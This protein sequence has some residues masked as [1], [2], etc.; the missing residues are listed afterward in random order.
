MREDLSFK[1]PGSV[2]AGEKLEN[3]G[4]FR[5]KL[6]LGLLLAGFV[7]IGV[8]L[9]TI[10]L[11]RHDFWVRYVNDQR[12]SAIVIYPKRGTIYD[13]NR[14]PLATSIEQEVLCVAPSRVTD[15]A[16][17][18][19]AISPYAKMR[20]KKIADKIHS[21]KLQL[22]YLRRGLDFKTVKEINAKK[23]EG[24]EFRSEI[25]RHYPNGSHASNLI[26]FA[27]LENK[28]LEGIEYKY[29]SHLAGEAGKQIVI[30][31]N[32]RREIAVLAQLVKE[33]RDGGD[34]VLTID[35]YIQHTTEKALDEI[36]RSF[37]PES[38]LAIVVEPKTG[39]V[40][41]MACRPT[42]DPNEPS[43]YKPHRLRN[44][45]ITDAFEPGSAFKAIAAASALERNV[46]TPRSHVYCEL[47]SMRFHRHTYNDVHPLADVTFA[48]VIA[49]SS[50]IG[51]IKVT[52]LLSP[53]Y[54]YG[55]IK[56]FGFGNP[57]GIDLPGES[58]GIVHHPS[59]WS[60]LSMG[61]LPIGQEI[62][63]TALQLAMAYSAIA[64]EGKLMRPF[65]I[66]K[67]LA[68]D[69]T[70]LKETMP[71][72]VR[73]V[74]RPE[75]AQTLTKLLELVITSGTGTEARIAGY[76]CAGK[77]GTAQKA[78]P[79]AGG[80]YRDKHVAVFSGFLPADDPAACITIVV[81]SPRGKKYYG[82]QVAAPAFRDIGREIMNHLEFPPTEL[83]DEPEPQRPAP[84][85][86]VPPPED[87]KAPLLIAEAD[88]V[89]IM[90]DVRGMTMTQIIEL[91]SEYSLRLEFEGS[92]VAFR[93]NPRAG[94]RLTK[95]QRC[96]IAFRR[97]DSE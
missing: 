70:I 3:P 52:N 24:I 47:G 88:G 13:C 97:V 11:L 69:G 64:N 32:S 14:R 63:V 57:T 51:M 71:E 17:L 59:Q 60:R 84:R 23:L 89:P 22:V 30:K 18:A 78:N 48:D 43:S 33:A 19:K 31:D 42:F 72:V 80:Y 4:R 10:H 28:G 83:A 77:T 95:G 76:R 53:E 90:P 29:D 50:N 40:L 46:I 91:L 36:V 73:T 75:T 21:T 37:S 20:A 44:R 27:N 8:K 61:S 55:R 7:A 87:D 35:E 74:I 45:V 6:C 16:N 68:P 39:K 85:Q 12:K 54:F 5:A 67:I 58:P 41:A 56:A 94:N 26:G 25:T 2:L 81:D 1:P 49:Q 86:N 65:V 96:Q 82:G 34:I 93:Q 92:G 79:V 15:V 66:S 9:A 62:G 38:A